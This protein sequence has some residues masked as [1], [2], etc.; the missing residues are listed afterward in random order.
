MF[1]AI[2]YHNRCFLLVIF[3]VWLGVPLLNLVG[4]LCLDKQ[5]FDFRAWEYMSA[6]SGEGPFR[7]GARFEKEIYGDLANMLNI[8]KFRQYRHQVF[9][10][11]SYGFR[12]PEYP[13]GTYFNIVVTGDSDMAGSSLTDHDTFS[14]RLSQ[15]LSCNVYN[16]APRSPIAFL[17]DKRFASKPPKVLIWEA[18]GRTITGAGYHGYAQLPVEGEFTVQKTTSLRDKQQIPQLT[19]YFSRRIF[20]EARWLLTGIHSPSISYID[21]VTGMLFYAP[22]IEM[23]RFNSRQR[24]LLT[25]LDGIERVHQICLRRGITLIYI[26]LPDK[27]DIYQDLLPPAIRQTFAA[28]NFMEELMD[29]LARR[30]IVYVNL[31]RAFASEAGSAPFLYFPDD[32]HWNQHGVKMAAHITA[33]LIRDRHLLP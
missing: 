14:A 17:A 22:S 10:T 25:V 28:P 21:K 18:I 7:A 15:V 13:A 23:L 33:K 9:S 19:N 27:E 29:G 3:L 12:N 1:K 6:T 30:G 5:F 31:R 8:A 11:D 32:T 26:P 2:R 16:Y 4:S 24:G 20:H